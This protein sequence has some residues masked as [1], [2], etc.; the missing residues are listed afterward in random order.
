LVE[1]KAGKMDFDG[2]MVK[3]DRRKGI[4]RV[5]KDAQGMM[6]F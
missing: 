5:M 3:P 4:I 2:K 1:F 6:Q